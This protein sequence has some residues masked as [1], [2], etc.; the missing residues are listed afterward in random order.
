VRGIDDVIISDASLSD[1]AY[2]GSLGVV[3]GWPGMDTAPP[4]PM[5]SQTRGV[6]DGYAAAGG[7]Y[8]EVAIA[9]AGHAPFLEQPEQFLSALESLLGSA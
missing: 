9:D 8:R 1:V 7:S 3:P 2:L 5:V 4:Q 6:L